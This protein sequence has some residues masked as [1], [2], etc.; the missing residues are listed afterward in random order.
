MPR[1][2]AAPKAAAAPKQVVI[3]G[4]EKQYKE[5]DQVYVQLS[6]REQFDFDDDDDTVKAE[7]VTKFEIAGI[8]FSKALAEIPAEITA[9]TDITTD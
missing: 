8:D 6:A 1:R 4:L 5:L 7:R 3:L 2:V 9:A